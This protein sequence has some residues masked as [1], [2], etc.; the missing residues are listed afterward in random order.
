MDNQFKSWAIVELMGHSR[1]AG[2]VEAVEVAGRGMLRVDVP[3]CEGHEKF[4]RYVSPSALYALT[5]VTEE[6]ARRASAA[7]RPAPVQLW[8]LPALPQPAS[9]T[10]VDDGES[11]EEGVED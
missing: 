5:P 3:E 4:T 8:Q 9:V 2:F 11:Y 1:M 10:A 6:M 7:F